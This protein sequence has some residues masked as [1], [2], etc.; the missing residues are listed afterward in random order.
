MQRSVTPPDQRF[1]P[2]VAEDGECW[3]WVGAIQAQ[4]YGV[5]Y[6]GKDDGGQ[7]RWARAHRYAYEAL[8]TDIP[9]G[10]DL[11]HL[12]RHRWCV[13]PWHLEPVTA[14]ENMLRMPRDVRDAAFRPSHCKHGHP[15]NAANTYV[16]P[17]T[18]F[19]YCR[20]CQKRR[21][22]AFLARKAVLNADEAVPLQDRR[23]PQGN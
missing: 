12:C 16:Q 6:L 3:R 1:W 2:K 20:T 19:R 10:L 18:G 23:S 13:N 21:Q 8:R 17:K 15:L 22:A 11:D 9:A 7:R 5:F 4:G 14:S